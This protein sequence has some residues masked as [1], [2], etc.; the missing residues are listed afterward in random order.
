MGWEKEREERKEYG[1]VRAEA[2]AKNSTSSSLADKTRGLSLPTQEL[3]KLVGPFE[4]SS[5]IYKQAKGAAKPRKMGVSR[6]SAAIL[7]P[8]LYRFKAV[9][10]PHATPERSFLST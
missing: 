10:T 1:D 4:G 7:S 2:S 6:G 5:E 9:K 3:T 8:L